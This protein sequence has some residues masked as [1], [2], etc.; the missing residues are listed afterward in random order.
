MA[1]PHIEFIHVQVLP[2]QDGLYAG[3]ERPGVTMR[4]L[5]LDDETGAASTMLRYPPGFHL[6]TPP[7]L[8]ADE[9][10]FV[11]EGDLSIG[12][13]HLG[14]HGY[15]FLPQ[16]ME[17]GA[18]T[19]AKGAVTLSLFS[20]A[21]EPGGAA[22][23]R[24]DKRIAIPDTRS[25]GAAT[26][27]RKHMNSEGFDHSGTVHKLLRKDPDTGEMSWLIG[28][29]PGWATSQAE[30][31]PIAEEEF[32]LG[33]DIHMPTGVMRSGGYFFRPPGIQHGPFGTVCGTLHFARCVGGGMATEFED[34][35]DALVYNA[36]YRPHL[37]P[38]LAQL[39]ATRPDREDCI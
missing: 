36:P 12:D 5:S 22:G 2:W 10:I 6:A 31:H 8:A 11:I 13:I 20:A 26:G 16:G 32:S 29:L 3:P 14:P 23:Y 7:A 9:E 37:P 17:R 21:P 30:T 25:I 15:A 35:P 18:M 19:S 39:A 33:G 27:P 1:R 28:L 38:D 4:M 24:P 34:K